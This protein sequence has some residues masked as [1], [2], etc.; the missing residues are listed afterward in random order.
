ML[1]ATLLF[2]GLPNIFSPYKP[3]ENALLDVFSIAASWFGSDLG[4]LDYSYGCYHQTSS[5][6][7]IFKYGC[8]L[9]WTIKNFT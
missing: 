3:M 2:R 6:H 4:I 1:V 7:I 9:S 5:E 8:L